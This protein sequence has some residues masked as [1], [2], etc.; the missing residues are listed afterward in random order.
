MYLD[1]FS[2]GHNFYIRIFILRGGH[3][4]VLEMFNYILLFT[5]F[6]PPKLDTLRLIPYSPGIEGAGGWET[7]YAPVLWEMS[8]FRFG[9][10]W[11]A[12][13]ILDSPPTYLLG[14]R[15]ADVYRVTR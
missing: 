13:S 15:S 12:D 1:N 10:C 3:M 11:L 6:S 14:L 2:F 4:P 9:I 5:W 7:L 8:P